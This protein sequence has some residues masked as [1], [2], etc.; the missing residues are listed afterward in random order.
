M[1]TKEYHKEYHAKWYKDNS[2]MRKKQIADR[3]V[4]VRNFIQEYKASS[5]CKNCPE[6]HTAT[7]DFHHRDSTKKVL[8]ISK[9]AR[10]GWG[11]AKL[12]RE[13]EKC[14]IL[15]SNCHRKLHHNK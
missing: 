2:E 9:A 1:N 8:E 14:D 7:L 11:I 12:R 3:K 6:N 5:K 10:D 13:I 4:Y 15:C